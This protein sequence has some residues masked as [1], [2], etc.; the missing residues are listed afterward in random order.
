MS[1]SGWGRSKRP[2]SADQIRKNG[3]TYEADPRGEMCPLGAHIRRANPRNAD[4]PRKPPNVVAF[5]LAL[6]G[7]GGTNPR[8]DVESPVR[9]HR[10]LRR[11]RE[12]GPGL[13]PSEARAPAPPNDPARGLRFL[14]VNA[15][16][17][18][19]FEFLQNAW[20]R[21][22]KFDGLTGESDPIVGNRAPIPGCPVTDGFTLPRAGGA[23]RRISGVPQFVT[24]QGGAY[25]FLPSLRALRYLATVSAHEGVDR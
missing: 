12:F 10:V 3:F 5:L 19:Q 21:N 17:M 15:N 6:L 4:F 14:A 24:V 7:F 23:R 25:F 22:T 8:E 18:R 9:F 16:I 20:M 2:C 1:T 13:T 11:G